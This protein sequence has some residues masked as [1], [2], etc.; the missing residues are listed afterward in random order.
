M[1]SFSRR[2][3]PAEGGADDVVNETMS[4]EKKKSLFRNLGSFFGHIVKAVKTDPNTKRT[5][6]R[7]TVEEQEHGDITLRRTT[8]EEI[9]F[10]ETDESENADA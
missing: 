5:V 10:K 4:V 2:A 6:L 8:I 9:E 7:K 3:C 1:K